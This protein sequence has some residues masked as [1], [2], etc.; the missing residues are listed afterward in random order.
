MKHWVARESSIKLQGGFA[1]K[2]LTHKGTTMRK[3]MHGGRVGKIQ[4]K[5]TSLYLLLNRRETLSMQAGEDDCKKKNNNCAVK[6]RRKTFLQLRT[7]L[8]PRISGQRLYTAVFL[9][10]VESPFTWWNTHSPDYL[11]SW[12]N[13][14]HFLFR[15]IYFVRSN[16]I[17]DC[18]C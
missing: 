9:V 15:L 5:G 3:V 13:R 7:A 4:K 17:R 14:D 12:E 6:K 1:G 18:D 11:Y 8:Q 2:P 10:L 16:L